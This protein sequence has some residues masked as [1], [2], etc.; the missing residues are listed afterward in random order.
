MPDDTT[1]LEETSLLNNA[2]PPGD[3]P[4]DPANGETLTIEV[5]RETIPQNFFNKEGEFQ[6]ESLTKAWK[7]GQDTIRDLQNAK[8][9]APETPDNYEYTF[10]DDVK[11]L[12]EKVLQTGE[13]GAEDPILSEFRKFAHTEQM[14]NEQ[15]NK[16]VNWYVSKT[17]ALIPDPVDQD[18]EIKKLGNNAQAIIDGTDKFIENLKASGLVDDAQYNEL[19]ITCS[20]AAGIQA[21]QAIRNFYGEAAVPNMRPEDIVNTPNAAELD[22]KM[23]DIHR[24]RLK[25]EID[26]RQADAEIQQLDQEFENVYG[27]AP[28]GSS[29]VRT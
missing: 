23:G 11:P 25:G 9:A 3:P 22:K 18:A 2:S 1:N 7:D 6:I 13:D 17:A 15:F 27:T 4:P 21:L 8:T 14:S 10:D 26:D 29:I 24:R 28:G 5:S 20:S 19:R 12:A 16:V